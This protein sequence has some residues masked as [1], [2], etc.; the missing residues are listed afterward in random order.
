MESRA[1]VI[2]PVVVEER[3]VEQFE[4][5]PP[6]DRLLMSLLNGKPDAG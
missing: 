2:A 4:A 5:C 1:F 6:T 3:V